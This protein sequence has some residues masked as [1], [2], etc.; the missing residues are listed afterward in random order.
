MLSLA[1]NLP[2]KW[3]PFS[4]PPPTSRDFEGGERRS[5]YAPPSG[6]IRLLHQPRWRF[7]LPT[8]L[9]IR[10]YA[11]IA[12]TSPHD[13]FA[14][15]CWGIW[16]HSSLILIREFRI[17]RSSIINLWLWRRCLNSEGG[18]TC[19]Q[20]LLSFFVPWGDSNCSVLL[21]TT[22]PCQAFG[23]CLLNPN[24]DQLPPARLMNILTDHHS[25][26][27]GSQ[28]PNK[29]LEMVDKAFLSS[30][31]RLVCCNSTAE[32]VIF[33]GWWGVCV[34]GR[35]H[36]QINLVG[37]SACYDNAEWWRQLVWDYAEQ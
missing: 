37:L 6:L 23:S 33:N 18:W 35:P 36:R 16:K 12:L 20:A 10:C 15:P 1:F 29:K 34:S 11:E 21:H 26:L 19:Q 32:Q 17:K 25:F 31:S 27:I 24:P 22:S 13:L 14:I 30:R 8:W 28:D 4:S 5:N 3:N 9:S 2:P 7:N